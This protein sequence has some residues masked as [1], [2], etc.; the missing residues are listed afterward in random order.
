MSQDYVT[1]M[2][3]EVDRLR[4]FYHSVA[5]AIR[6]YEAGGV[7]PGAVINQVVGALASLELSASAR[8]LMARTIPENIE[9]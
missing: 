3:R 9:L 6:D 1:S 2:A 5:S 4:E 8:A 7:T